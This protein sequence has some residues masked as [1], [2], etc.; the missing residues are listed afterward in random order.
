[1]ALSLALS[2]LVT[3]TAWADLPPDLVLDG[4]A[5]AGKV[6]ANDRSKGNCVACHVMA[7]SESPGAIGPV[8]I[9]MQTRFPSKKVLA[10]QIWDATVKNPEA[11]MPPFGKNEIL[12]N[13]DFV[14]VVEFVWSL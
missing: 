12:S 2:T 1:M 10:E 5:Q 8:L 4:D 11:V 14:D 9:A 6:V 3:G 13:K 7:G